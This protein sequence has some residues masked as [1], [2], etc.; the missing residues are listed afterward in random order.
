VELAL[1]GNGSFQA[2]VDPGARVRWL[3]WPRFDSDF[4]FAHLLDEDK[5]GSFSVDVR[6]SQQESH[7][8]YVRDT[9]V[10]TTSITCMSKEAGDKLGL[11]ITDV[12]PRFLDNGALQR[13]RRLVRRIVPTRGRPR[14][15]IGC[16]P[17]SSDAQVVLSSTATRAGLRW[18]RGTNECIVLTANSHVE[19][20][21]EG[22]D[23][24]LDEPLYLCLD[25]GEP[26]D[27]ADVAIAAENSI[28][29]TISYWQD[30]TSKASLPSVFRDE[31]V[32]SMITLALHQFDDTGALSAAATTSI[33]EHPGSGRTWDYRY[34]WPRDSYFSVEALARLGHVEPARRFVE[35]I[36]QVERLQPLY[37]IG[38]EIELEERCIDGL[39]G[40]GGDGP[41]RVG[42]QA[43]RQQQH[44]IY[45]ELL[46]TAE[47]AVDSQAPDIAL[48]DLS[49]ILLDEIEANLH[50]PDSGLWEKRQ[51]PAVH[52][53]SL[54]MHWRGC[55]A[56]MEVA[57]C[58]SDTAM[59]KRALRLREAARATIEEEC[60]REDKGYFADSTRGD[61]ADASLFMLVTTGFLEPSDPRARSH[62]EHTAKVL[63][64]R[65]HLLY[66][67][68]HDDGL[69][70]T[71]ATFT[72]CGFWYAEA[73]AVLG[74]WKESRKVV[75]AILGHAN[76]VGLL[77]EDI[78]P[79][80]GCLWGNFPQTYSHV[81]I[82]SCALALDEAES[83]CR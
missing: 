42:N 11:E 79:E 66:R 22:R 51:A 23:F 59:A 33:P 58:F 61:F 28:A 64:V 10:V 34:C 44:D 21:Q 77:S 2:L 41:V 8:S 74:D 53:F 75:E 57:G 20:I 19:D 72:V 82:I 15:R 47:V 17:V 43:Y 60:W 67:Y 65:G 6:E 13:P 35:F 26:S 81:G 78:D 30:W 46:A 68:L 31:V 9:A 69:G 12:A 7:Q 16:T 50:A 73:L 70:A 80:N 54:L 48:R 25:W 56:A 38:G 36:G 52:T 63:S 62:V 18:Q 76:H 5:G 55:C 39:A 24:V 40:Y 32:R 37:G 83:T 14:I 49:R 71:Q 29:K 27:L 4:V 45:G 1:I 3:C